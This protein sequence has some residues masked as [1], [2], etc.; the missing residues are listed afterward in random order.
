MTAALLTLLTGLV[1][2]TRALPVRV[3][4]A[5]GAVLIVLAL[6][7]AGLDRFTGIL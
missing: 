4:W 3:Q 2:L 7:G 1:I 6:L 5:V